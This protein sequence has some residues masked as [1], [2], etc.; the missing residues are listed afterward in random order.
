[1]GPTTANPSTGMETASVNEKSSY[2]KGVYSLRGTRLLAR[3]ADIQQLPKGVYIVDG[4]KRI[5]K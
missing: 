1:M 2:S 4:T 3:A 5:V